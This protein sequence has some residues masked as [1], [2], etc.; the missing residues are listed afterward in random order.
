[1]N[2][3]SRF[4]NLN[5][6]PGRHSTRVGRRILRKVRHGEKERPGKSSQRKNGRY[7]G[8]PEFAALFG[9]SLSGFEGALLHEEEPEEETRS[10]E[11]KND[12]M[13]PRERYLKIRK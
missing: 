3:Q 2:L 4:P 10:D 12:H 6:R 5:A 8:Q 1:M 11:N 7:W 9:G 13:P